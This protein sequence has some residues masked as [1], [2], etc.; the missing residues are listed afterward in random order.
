MT[1]PQAW[2]PS[3][4]TTAFAPVRVG[5]AE[6]LH[7]VRMPLVCRGPVLREGFPRVGQTRRVNR[8]GPPVSRAC[9]RA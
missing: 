2:T 6:L 5:S 4:D 8:R 3:V 9:H 1:R 7:G